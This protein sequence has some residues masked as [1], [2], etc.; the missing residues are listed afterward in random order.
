MHSVDWLHSI[1]LPIHFGAEH[2]VGSVLGKATYGDC[3]LCIK[4]LP[5][6]VIETMGYYSI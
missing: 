5:L 3:F 4:E 2:P 1:E 6:V